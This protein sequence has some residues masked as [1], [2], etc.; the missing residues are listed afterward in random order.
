MKSSEQMGDHMRNIKTIM[1]MC[2]LVV[3][4]FSFNLYAWDDKR[5]HPILS[6]AA[7]RNSVLNTPYAE[8]YLG[9]RERVDEIING[10]ELY[11]WVRRGS[12]EEDKWPRF[13][14]HFHNP[15]NPIDSW[16]T[17]GLDDFLFSGKSSILWAQDKIAQE[18]YSSGDWSWETTRTF[19]YNSLLAIDQ[20]EKEIEFSNALLGLGHQI[21]LLQDMS[22]PAHVRNDAHPFSRN[23]GGALHIE[24]WAKTHESIIRNIATAGTVPPTI[25]LNQSTIS[26]DENQVEIILSPTARL[27]DNDQYDGTNPSVS[28]LNGLA[29]YTSANFFS[30]DTIFTEDD[31]VSDPHRF[32][33][34]KKTS[35]D[36]QTYID[37]N[38]LPETTTAEDGVIDVGF[39]IAKTGDGE[40]N[41]T[42]FV[43]PTYLLKE[44]ATEMGPALYKR[45]FYLDEDYVAKLIPR[46]V[47]YSTALLDYFFRGTIEITPPNDFVYSVIDG[48]AADQKFEYIKVNLQ[49]TTQNETMQEGS[50]VAVARYIRRI[51][52]VSDLSS[53]EPPLE[54]SREETYSYS[55]SAPVVI[56]SLTND[57]ANPEQ[58]TFD[59]SSDPIPAGIT[60][61]SLQI[62]FQGTLGNEL[63]NAIAVGMIDLAEPNHIAI[64][65]L[66]D[67]FY[68]QDTLMTAA[69]IRDDQ[70]LL[71]Y[72]DDNCTSLLPYIDPFPMDTDIGFSA[73]PS[74]PPNNTVFS[75]TSL[76]PGRY[77]RI[78]VLTDQSPF[79]MHI[80]RVAT[81]PS[82]NDTSTITFAAVKNQEGDAGVFINTAVSTFRGITSH[83]YSGHLFYCPDANNIQNAVWPP[84]VN[85]QAVPTDITFP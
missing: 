70:E 38:K 33:F 29:D 65:N 53:N 74:I 78:I 84:A 55:I 10:L 76:A 13:F 49:N 16:S 5:V 8:E 26:K 17:S 42:H 54:D 68:L 51:D 4:L 60:D 62:V 14:N 40:N 59:F 2:F 35:T 46:A 75:Y 3:L 69:E 9:I 47:G 56:Q 64:W 31:D 11:Q 22:V 50:L 23:A 27:S 15:I 82:F 36:I 34:P 52:Y 32:P 63:D 37:A 72:I 81:T 61:L 44:H 20:N 83:N 45:L 30:D 1:G 39:W 58:F 85:N 12:E 43:K 79:V 66:T 67:R 25:S 21:H 28:T 73:S 48:S 18:G 80:H 57:P 7:T 71:D 19:F 41:V 77:G 24:K 6:E